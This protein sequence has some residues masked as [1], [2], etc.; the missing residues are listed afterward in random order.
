[1]TERH[2]WTAVCALSD[3]LADAADIYGSAM[4]AAKDPALTRELAAQ[5]DRLRQLSAQVRGGSETAAGS[6]PQLIDELRLLTDRLTGD[7]DEAALVASREARADL[8]KLIDDYLRSPELS[9]DT[10][11]I[12]ADVRRRVTDGRDI[13]SERGGLRT[14]PD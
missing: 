12:F 13:P 5:A 3:E 10:L 2:D 11:A 6:G 1:M 7:D 14:L 8:L 9:K 4:K